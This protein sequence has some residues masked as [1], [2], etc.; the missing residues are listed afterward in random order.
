LW[1]PP[2][3]HLCW[4]SIELEIFLWWCISG[5]S[6]RFRSNSWGWGQRSSSSSWS[7]SHSLVRGFFEVV[8]R[9]LH[10]TQEFETTE[11]VTAYKKMTATVCCLEDPF[12]L[13]VGRIALIPIVS[14]RERKNPFFEVDPLP[15]HGHFTDQQKRDWSVRHGRRVSTTPEAVAELMPRKQQ[16]P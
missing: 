3:H 1:F 14:Q 11:E 15:C 9:T 4:W 6:M 5:D 13:F 16:M 7:S 12:L 2:M 10:C 8:L